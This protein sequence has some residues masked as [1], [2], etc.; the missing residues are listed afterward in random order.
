MNEAK[1][2]VVDDEPTLSEVI[3]YNL[4]QAGYV[5]VTAADADDTSRH[6]KEE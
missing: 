5:T 3:S 2:L 6:F 4:R 1:I